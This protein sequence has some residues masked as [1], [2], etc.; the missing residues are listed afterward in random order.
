MDDDALRRLRQPQ[1]VASMTG[2]PARTPRSGRPIEECVAAVEAVLAAGGDSRED[3][4]GRQGVLRLF[5]SPNGGGKAPTPDPEL[6][7][8]LEDIRRRHFARRE[9]E[10][11]QIEGDDAA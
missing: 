8:L 6:K 3:A 2:L 9:R 10:G 11:R 7:V 1:R 4:G 5:P